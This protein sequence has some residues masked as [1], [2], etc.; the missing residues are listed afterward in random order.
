MTLH[1]GAV[2]FQL[3]DRLDYC[4]LMKRYEMQVHVG[5]QLPVK[6]SSFSTGSFPNAVMAELERLLYDRSRFVSLLKVL[7][8][9]S[10]L[11]MLFSESS[12]SC[13]AGND[14]NASI[15]REEEELKV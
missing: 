15:G 13:R 4:L 12:N 8:D 3:E 7:C 11:V 5:H 1:A 2:T 14:S 9:M 10:M 6:C